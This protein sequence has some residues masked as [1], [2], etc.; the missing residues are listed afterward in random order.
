MET[1]RV[2]SASR[3]DFVSAATF[4]TAIEANKLREVVP[5]DGLR[6]EDLA[7][8]IRHALRNLPAGSV[9]AL[10]GE[11]GRGKT[12]V[13]ARVARDEWDGG[14]KTLEGG[15]LWLNP[16]QYG[17]ADLLQPLVMELGRRAAASQA[18]NGQKA[19]IIETAGLILRASVQLGFGFA[20]LHTPV[21]TPID[22]AAKATDGLLEHLF[23]PTGP[24]PAT[25]PIATMAANFR[26]L[27]D[28]ALAAQNKGPAA[29]LL[30]CVDDIDRCLPERQ[31]ALLQAFHFLLGAQARASILIAFDP[32]L[33]REAVHT[34]YH[35][36]N[37]DVDRFLDK[38]FHLRVPLPSL[39]GEELGPMIENLFAKAPADRLNTIGLGAQLAE[40][41]GFQSGEADVR[42]AFCGV[43]QSS[44]CANPRLV[45]RIADRTLLFAYTGVSGPKLTGPGGAEVFFAWLLIC[46]RFTG[47]RRYLQRM[48]A[49]DFDR[50]L[51]SLML[52]GDSRDGSEFT[53]KLESLLGEPSSKVLVQLLHRNAIKNAPKLGELWRSIDQSLRLSGL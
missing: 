32:E 24:P 35:A 28:L 47:F 22:A 36:P 12:D 51:N 27:V 20:K 38:M 5:P 15:C 40:V 2:S 17:N 48:E 8:T 14:D 26:Q 16:W 21:P 53:R 52:T 44:A 39:N 50:W 1:S 3:F 9:I 43:L 4:E 45:R 33:V 10:E 25:D 11:W 31:V 37:F 18:N 19:K 46:E 29:R 13:L 6:H 30:I 49:V 23:L 41:L 7:R 34:H 42:R